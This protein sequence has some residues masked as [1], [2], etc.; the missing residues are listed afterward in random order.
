MSG[1]TR[2]STSEAFVHLT[3]EIFGWDE[4]TQAMKEF[5]TEGYS[6]IND[7]VTMTRDEIEVMKDDEKIF[8][9]SRRSCY[10]MKS[11]Y[12]MKSVK[13]GRMVYSHHLIGRILIESRLKP[14]GQQKFLN[15]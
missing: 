1:V 11:F 10:F 3:T 12:T 6:T 8:Q 14:S 15:L 2:A 9:E 13:R 7:F 5:R 4:D